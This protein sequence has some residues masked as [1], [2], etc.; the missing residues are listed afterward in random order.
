MEFQTNL[1]PTLEELNYLIREKQRLVTKAEESYESLTLTDLQN[2]RELQALIEYRFKKY[3][4][5]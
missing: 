2:K 4:I 3:G 1:P 5:L